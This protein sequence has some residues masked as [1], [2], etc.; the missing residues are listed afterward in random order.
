[1]T[2]QLALRCAWHECYADNALI[3]ILSRK[4]TAVEDIA[5]FAD[6]VFRRCAIVDVIIEVGHVNAVL[7]TGYFGAVGSDPYDTDGAC[8]R[9]FGCKAEYRL[10]ELC[11]EERVKAVGTDL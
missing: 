9:C 10:Q 2:I 8:G 6:T 1:M 3:S 7:R 4:L 5:G 11:E